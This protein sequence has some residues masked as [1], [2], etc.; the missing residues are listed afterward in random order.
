MVDRVE[1]QDVD[2]SSTR[3]ARQGVVSF[4]GSVVGAL[5]GF[6]LTLVLARSFGS[7]GA[8]VVLQ[9]IALFTIGLSVG[10]GGLDTAATWIVPRLLISSPEEVGGTIRHTLVL[11][12]GGGVVAA[13]VTTVVARLVFDREVFDAVLASAWAMPL[14]GVTLVGTA[15]LRALGS[16]KAYI[17]VVQVLVPI[18]RVVFILLV[19]ALGYGAMTGAFAWALPYA[20]GAVLT[21][22]VLVR[23]LSR[24]F[25]T[26]L[27]RSQAT[28]ETR[29]QVHR[30]SVGRSAGTVLEQGLLW[31]DVLL[32][33]IL[34]DT[35]AAGI[36]GTASR[37]VA[38][39]LIVD[40]ALRFVM[41]PIF[42]ALL[43]SDRRDEVQE[44]YVRSTVWLVLL[45]VPIYLG[46][47]VYAPLVLTWLGPGFVE[48]Q[49][50]MQ[51][52]CLGTA[53]TLTAG[54]IHTML[55]M[56]GRSGQA[57]INKFVVLSTNVAGN[58]LL[59][60]VW[61]IDA[62]ASVWVFSMLLDAVLASWQVHR[63][64][65]V[66]PRPAGIAYALGVALLTVGVPALAWRAWL[67]ATPGSMLGAAVSA[68]VLLGTW[69]YLDRRR[70]HMSEL[71][72]PIRA[73]FAG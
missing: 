21:V 61:G 60:P 64:T 27:L 11:S 23:G 36:Y 51:I 38:A 67:G 18:L 8:G 70:L 73:R 28:A 44:L 63:A 41:A 2:H 54:N 4:G 35:T 39:G 72:D 58:L 31:L 57:A 45:S 46:L 15:A 43:Y 20:L 42:S 65:G 53:L 5:L 14:A 10:K 34:L 49:V 26:G 30:Y 50:A 62:A 48:G 19:A 24:R 13:L 29:G 32:V 17:V 56:A 37:F 55:L 9:A 16:I 22:A 68:A 25:G 33:G 47:A 3:I 6:V 40:T 71:I 66:G 12:L 52:L 69:I 7:D 59:V 1:P